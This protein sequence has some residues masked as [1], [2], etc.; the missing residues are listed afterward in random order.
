MSLVAEWREVLDDDILVV[1]VFIDFSKAFDM[2][3]HYRSF[4]GIE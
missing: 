2:V 1:S 3:N 4:P